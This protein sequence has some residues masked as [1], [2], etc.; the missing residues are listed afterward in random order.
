MGELIS[1]KKIAATIIDELKQQTSGMKVKPLLAMVLVGNDS[2]SEI[3]V[4]YKERASLRA[5]FD[6]K[7]VR[8]SENIS[9]ETLLQEIEKL[10]TD[11]KIHGFIVQLPLPKQI[12]E[13]KIIDAIS[14]LKDAD[15]FTTANLGNL[16]VGNKTILP[17]TVVG[18]MRMLETVVSDF[19]G[20]NVVVVGAS[21]IVGKP[22]GVLLLNQLATVTT[23]NV[24]TK[25]LA[26]HIKNAD[27]LVVAAGKAG[28]VSK[29]MVKKGAVVIDVGINRLDDGSICGDVSKEVREVAGFTSPVPGG[30]GPMTVAML[31]SNTLECMKLQGLV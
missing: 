7:L 8:L 27:I 22:L 17:A 2:A 9:Q 26:E 14:P 28:L 1:G 4:R 25:N 12:D 31:L 3:Y 29:N 15:G 24:D 13:K 19:R 16:F 21:N 23:C 30:V 6:S 10:N 18:V 5:G 20:K 11:K